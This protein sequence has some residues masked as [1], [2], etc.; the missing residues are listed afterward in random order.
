[1]PNI[2]F[3]SD[4]HFNHSNILKYDDRPYK[5]VDEMNEALIANHNAIVG[6]NDTVYNLGDFSMKGSPSAIADL[7]KRMNGNIFLLRGNH[8]RQFPGEGFGWVKD[9][10]EMSIDGVNVV[11]S[12]YPFLTWNGEHRGS[13][14][15]SGHTHSKEKVVRPN[16]KGIHV[17]VTSWDYKPVSWYEIKK[18]AD[19]IIPTV[20][21]RGRN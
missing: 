10:H 11:L 7:R 2:F 19:S 4:L 6:K 8:D 17:G 3:T 20:D 18:L 14:Q 9:Y 5:T 1:M 13:I 12:H 15:L 21:F 16:Y